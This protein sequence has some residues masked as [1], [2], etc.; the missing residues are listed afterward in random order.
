MPEHYLTEV[1]TAMGT[2]AEELVVESKGEGRAFADKL[3]AAVAQ[4]RP[5]VMAMN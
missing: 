3:A 2:V 4:G 1:S 5:A